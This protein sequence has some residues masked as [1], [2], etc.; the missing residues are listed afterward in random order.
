MQLKNTSKQVSVFLLSIFFLVAGVYFLLHQ[1]NEPSGIPLRLIIPAV[2][3]NT[4]VESVGTTKEGL[5]G[6]P[7]NR[8]RVA[9]WKEG[10]KPGE[11]GSAVITGHYGW[12]NKNSSAF[13]SLSM[14]RVKDFVFVEDDRGIMTRFVVREIKI[15]NKDA[16]TKDLVV[17][18]DGIA[19]LNLITCSGIWNDKEKEYEDRLVILTDREK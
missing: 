11:I 2:N 13:D 3:L 9:W 1:N 18:N 14:L 6:I 4:L 17:S 7:A 15:Y 19:H 10:V 8:E 16:T 5:I 12:K